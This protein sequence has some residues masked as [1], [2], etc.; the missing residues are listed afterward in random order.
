MRETN[1]NKNLDE[2]ILERKYD[3]M[4]EKF[5]NSGMRAYYRIFNPSNCTW[6]DDWKLWDK[7]AVK[8]FADGGLMPMGNGYR[9][10][11]Q[12]VMMTDYL[13]NFCGKMLG[14]SVAFKSENGGVS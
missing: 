1:W 11:G 9:T 6:V 7:E 5:E 14:V 3:N 12:Y 8:C 4:M 13:H 2:V 10:Y